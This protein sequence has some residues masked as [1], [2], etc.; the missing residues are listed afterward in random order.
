LNPNG[1]LDQTF[2]AGAG[3]GHVGS[4]PTQ[5]LC[6]QNDD[7]IIIGGSFNTYVMPHCRTTEQTDKFRQEN[8]PRILAHLVAPS[9]GRL[10]RNQKS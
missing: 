4:T 3:V 7:K 8:Q 6:I 10:F 5:T 2:K 9:H 1:S